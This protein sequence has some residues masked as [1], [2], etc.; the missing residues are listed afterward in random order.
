MNSGDLPEELNFFSFAEVGSCEHVFE[1]SQTNGAAAALTN[2]TVVSRL[3][4]TIFQK[5]KE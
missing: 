2:E 1:T 3:T 5:G 4:N